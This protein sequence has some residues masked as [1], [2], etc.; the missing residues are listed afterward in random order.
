MTSDQPGEGFGSG[1]VPTF[2]PS[3]PTLDELGEPWPTLD[4]LGQDDGHLVAWC[5]RCQLPCMI[6]YTPASVAWPRCRVCLPSPAPRVLLVSSLDSLRW[7]SPGKP[8]KR[9]PTGRKEKPP[10]T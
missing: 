6:A 8:R 5:P 4:S 1:N 10:A 3:P 2:P 7:R 9:P